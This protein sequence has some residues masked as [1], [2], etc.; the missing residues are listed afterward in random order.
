MEKDALIKK[1]KNNKNI[2][3]K[4][5]KFINDKFKLGDTIKS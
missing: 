4:K 3:N 1:Y 2:T 5:F